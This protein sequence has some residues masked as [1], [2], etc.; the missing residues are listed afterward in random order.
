MT[1]A[2][3]DKAKC[4]R[5]VCEATTSDPTRDRWQLLEFPNMPLRFTGYYCPSCAAAIHEL[6]RQ[7]GVEPIVKDDHGSH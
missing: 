1:G 4:T 2:M 7:E 3:S 6:L 5:S